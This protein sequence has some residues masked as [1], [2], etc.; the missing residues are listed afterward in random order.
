MNIP[1]AIAKLIIRGEVMSKKVLKVLSIISILLCI[2]VILITASISIISPIPKIENT[3]AYTFTVE[4]VK[5]F[6]S[7]ATYIG[8]KEYKYELVVLHTLVSNSV[9][10]SNLSTGDPIIVREYTKNS[11]GQVWMLSVNGVDI[12]TLDD[13]EKYVDG[14]NRR[15]RSVGIAFS[16]FFAV[17]FIVCFCG[18]KG[19]FSN[20][21]G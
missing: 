7:V 18:Y 14:N 10:L 11:A 8:I 17:T 9:A 6:E 15:F 12:I 20:H 2:M 5:R 16:C 21:K 4:Y 1:M 13:S 3:T 19:V